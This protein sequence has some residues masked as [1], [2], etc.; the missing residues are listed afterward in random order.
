M[1][2]ETQGSSQSF[3]SRGSP[4]GTMWHTS[5]C[6]G[7][8]PSKRMSKIQQNAVFHPKAPLGNCSERKMW[9]HQIILHAFTKEQD[10]NSQEILTWL[11]VWLSVSS[12]LPWQPQ[13]L[14]SFVGLSPPLIAE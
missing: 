11:V 7:V 1:T 3:P 4:E 5:I 2:M 8:R 10:N 12:S 6:G 9:P 13:I 14:Q